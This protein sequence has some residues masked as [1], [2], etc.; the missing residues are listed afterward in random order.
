MRQLMALESHSP[1][2]IIGAGAWGTALAQVAARAIQHRAR[3]EDNNETVTVYTHRAAL[4]EQVNRERQNQPSLPGIALEPQ[5]FFTNHRSHLRQAQTIIL[6]VPSDRLAESLHSLAAEIAP[7]AV[8][9]SAAKGLSNDHALRM[10]ELVHKIM[11]SNPVAALSGPGFAGEVARGQPTA[12]TLAAETLA[13]AESQLPALVSRSFRPYPS[14]DLIGTEIG[15]VAKNVIA[16]A[17]GIAVGMGF[18]DNV[19]AALITRGLAELTRYGLALGGRAETLSGLAGVGDLVLTCSGHQSRNLRFGIALGQ[20]RD[21]AQAL[22]EFGTV[23][24]IRTAR[25]ITK[26]SQRRSLSMPI[27]ESVEAVLSGQASRHDAVESLLS[28]PIP[29]L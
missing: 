22:E 15:G 2:A 10:S 20:G 7:N 8:L 24:G 21:R 11:P 5:I 25:L 9:I 4:A 29:N 18:G 17:C 1:I 19:R 12:V 23:E 13:I 28:R 14:D 3:T 6:A 26:E 27:C 16:I